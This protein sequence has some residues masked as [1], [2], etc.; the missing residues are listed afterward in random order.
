MN[1]LTLL[2]STFLIASCV[3]KRIVID[4]REK[5]KAA[6]NVKILSAT[7]SGEL[8]LAE[9]DIPWEIE[10]GCGGEKKGTF[11]SS[12]SPPKTFDIGDTCFFQL[13]NFKL[14]VDGNPHDYTRETSQQYWDTNQAKSTTE[15]KAFYVSKNT[16]TGAFATVTKMLEKIDKDRAKNNLEYSIGQMLTGDTFTAILTALRVGA[17][18]EVAPYPNFVIDSMSPEIAEGNQVN[19]K[20]SLRCK[21]FDALKK[22][23]GP[24]TSEQ[25]EAIFSEEA[26]DPSKK[27]GYDAGIKMF[28]GSTDKLSLKGKLE[29]ETFDMEFKNAEIGKDYYLIL[30]G[31]FGDTSFGFTS[32]PFTV[33]DPAK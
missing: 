9:S 2:L 25:I 12:D 19:V 4:K 1:F 24:Y 13:Q 6:L 29:G 11:K 21:E 10:Y 27:G 22:Q 7:S 16:S 20:L 28:T 30:K 3:P 15:S 17:Q 14:S 8:E 31:K 18:F 26:V 5:K 23:C 33:P 32:L